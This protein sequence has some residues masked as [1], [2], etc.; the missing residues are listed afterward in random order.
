MHARLPGLGS[1]AGVTPGPTLVSWVASGPWTRLALPV[2]GDSVGALLPCPLAQPLVVGLCSPAEWE[3]FSMVIFKGKQVR[4]L[5]FNFLLVFLKINKSI[6][7]IQY[8]NLNRGMKTALVFGTGVSLPCEAP[9][10]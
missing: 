10:L 2:P 9:G 6:S 7:Y 1:D 4:F 8:L 5:H 3:G